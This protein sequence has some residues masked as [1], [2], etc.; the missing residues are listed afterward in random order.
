MNPRMRPDSSAVDATERGRL[1]A[2]DP[3]A[4]HRGTRTAV[5]VEL[6]H[7]LGVHPV[8]VVGAEHDDVV[9]VLVVDQVH[10]LI[11]GIRGTGVPP[12]AKPLLR[13]NRGDV[14]PGKAG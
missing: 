13:R 6:D 12:G 4:R 7:L 8:H 14:L 10:R 11:D 5:D 1:G 3:D 9:G 2:R